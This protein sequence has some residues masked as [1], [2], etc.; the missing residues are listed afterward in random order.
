VAEA[1][2]M[3]I[4]CSASSLSLNAEITLRLVRRLR[5]GIPVM[6]GGHHPSFYGPE[7]LERGATVVVHGEGELTMAEVLERIEK[8][9]GFPE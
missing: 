9:R 4:T 2:A 6:L 7:W 8:N 5:P 1:D 3:G